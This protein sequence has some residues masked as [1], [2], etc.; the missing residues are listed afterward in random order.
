MIFVFFLAHAAQLPEFQLTIPSFTSQ[1]E[2]VKDIINARS[3][4]TTLGVVVRTLNV[5]VK[6]LRISDGM[7]GGVLG[8]LFDLCLQ[9]DELYSNPIEGLDEDIRTKVLNTERA[10]M[11]PI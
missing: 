1:A 9:L 11:L 7:S 2:K 6:A 4:W 8:K 3:F 10:C 5:A